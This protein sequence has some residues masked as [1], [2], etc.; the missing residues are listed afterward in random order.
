MARKIVIA[1]GKGGVGKTTVAAKLCAYLSMRGERVV[2]CDADFALNNVDVVTGVEDAVTYDLVDVIEGRCRAKQALVRHPDFPNL[3]I[4]TSAHSAPERYVSP[5]AM[6]LVLESLSPQ[7]DFIFIDA[8]AGVEEGF[9]RAVAVADEAIIVTTPQ[10]SAL[11]DADKAIALLKGYQLQSAF[12]VVNKVRGDLL[13]KGD[14]L[15][16]K[17]IENLL[18]TPV[19]GILPE[20]YAIYGGAFGDLHPAVKM[21]GKNVLLGRKKIYDVTKKYTGVIGAIRRAIKRGLA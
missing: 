6:K 21:L 7:F 5:Q 3:H 15:T 1:S 13:Y 12:V 16:P 17:E 11:R 14:C 4:L 18:K 10:I 8:P 2:L 20:E 19:L 9:H